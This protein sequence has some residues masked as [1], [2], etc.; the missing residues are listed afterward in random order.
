MTAAW[1]A[2]V[3][4]LAGLVAWAELRRKR[5]RGAWRAAA[6]V[7]A[8]LSLAALALGTGPARGRSGA[9][10]AVIVTRGARPAAVRR[11]ADS[12][13]AVIRVLP[14]AG[15]PQRFGAGAV[16]VADLRALLRGAPS[17]ERIIVAG[18]GLD[19]ASLEAAGERSLGFAPAPGPPGVAAAEW[20]ATVSRGGR[21]VVR[22]TTTGLDPGTLVSLGGPGASADSARVARDSTFALSLRPRAEG[23]FDYLLRA[24]GVAETLGVAVTPPRRTAVL[25][26][27]DAPSFESRYLDDW[28][29]RTGGSLAARTRVSRDRF[30]TRFVARAPAALSP[31]SRALLDSFDVVLLDTRTLN[32]LARG[33]RA[34]LGAAVRGGLGLAVVAND[35]PLSG[36]APLGD[37][38]LSAAPGRE[39]RVSWDGSSGGAAVSLAPFRLRAGSTAERL[40]TDSTGEAVVAWRPEGAGAVLLTLVANPSRW[41]LGGD[42]ERFADY[43]SLL[44]GAVARA[45]GR[46]WR[47]TH[48]AAVDRPVGLLRRG[49]GIAAARIEAP[50]GASDSVY[51]AQDPLEPERWEGRWWPRMGGWHRI[52]DDSSSF[53]VR[54]SGGWIAEEAAVRRRATAARITAGRGTGQ[55][56]TEGPSRRIPDWVW[57]TLLL[58]SLAYLW[59]AETPAAR[60]DRSAAGRSRV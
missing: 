58:A 13:G 51:L 60:G 54:V 6:G 21:L 18:W 50:S 49:G 9:R 11:L 42:R 4:F 3:A 17:I 15:D 56:D 31:L 32:A 8:V 28:I 52:A 2:L 26:I 5:P 30:R 25:L 46:E 20:S 12:A 29:R 19:S 44:L 23:R 16:R 27:E 36:D 41:Q 39:R 45:P 40:V 37:L 10:A 7:L 34:L 38:A 24:G 59:S 22:G 35:P 43:W 57:L 53:D 48:P 55:G 1:S 14:D 33:D 47:A